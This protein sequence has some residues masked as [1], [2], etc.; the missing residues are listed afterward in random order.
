MNY[1][2]PAAFGAAIAPGIVIHVYPDESVDLRVSNGYTLGSGDVP[3]VKLT[4]DGEPGTFFYPKGAK[5]AGLVA[6]PLDEFDNDVV[7]LEDGSD[8]ADI[9]DLLQ[10]DAEYMTV[11]EVI[12]DNNYKVLRAQDGSLIAAHE[13]GAIVKLAV[14]PPAS[15]AVAA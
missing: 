15:Q 4:G 13:V 12:N 8:V 14:P 5:G 10:I 7:A 9:D 11:I 6:Q 2:Q 1:R 3:H